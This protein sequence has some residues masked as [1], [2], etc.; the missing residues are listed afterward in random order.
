M[1]KLTTENINIIAEFVGSLMKAYARKGAKKTLNK[2]KKDP[3]I[4]KSLEKIS[5]LDKETQQAIEKRIKTNPE[6]KKDIDFFKG[7]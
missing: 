2:I 5:Q 4:R 7:L 1:S 6:L 3:V